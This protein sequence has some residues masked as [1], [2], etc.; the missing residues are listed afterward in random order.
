VTCTVNDGNGNS[1]SCSFTVTVVDTTK[2]EITCPANIAVFTTDSSG[3]A[4]SFTVVAEDLCSGTAT[5]V[6]SPSSGS[7]FA[8]GTT[9]VNCTATD[10]S[11]NSSQCSFSVTVVLNHA[12]VAGNN[13][14]GA[15]ENHSRAV[16][17][18]K[19]LDDD[20]DADNDELTIT[21]VSATSAQGG[22]VT[23]S[24]TEVTYM[25][26]P[27]FVGTDSFTYTVSDGR[28]G[29]A[30]ATVTVQVYSQNDPT[31]NRIGAITM[32]ANGHAHVRFAGI[33]GMTCIVERSTDLHTWTNIGSFTVPDDGI[34]DFEDA[35]P[36]TGMAF[37][38]TGMQ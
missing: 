15:L 7:V 31:M 13:N 21:E 12:P 2:P 10:A 25:P 1:A 11:S 6:C 9:T 3:T 23:L 28:G 4:V 35:N 37:Y 19:L 18:E 30:T 38:R 8:V 27:N 16:K 33:P 26:A 14:M 32:D 36:P 24:S 20:T 29:I 17:I 34:A 5:V 22:T